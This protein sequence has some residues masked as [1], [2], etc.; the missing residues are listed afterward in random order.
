MIPQSTT[1]SNIS[2]Y[3]CLYCYHV[4]TI[5][6]CFKFQRVWF[7]QT[8]NITVLLVQWVPSSVWTHNEEEILNNNNLLCGTGRR[9]FRWH[10]QVFV[11]FF[12]HCCCSFFFVIVSVW[13]PP[14]SFFFFFRFPE[15]CSSSANLLQVAWNEHIFFFF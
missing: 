8:G 15:K 9:I 6:M 11:M 14:P 1:I 2:N 12:F 5:F 4:L 3:T 13:N 10:N 7:Y